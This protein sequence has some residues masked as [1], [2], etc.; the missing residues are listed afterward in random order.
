MHSWISSNEQSSVYENISE[1]SDT[2]ED[3]CNVPSPINYQ[4]NAIRSQY[5]HYLQSIDVEAIENRYHDSPRNS[6]NS[7]TNNNN[8]N[9]V[10]PENTCLIVGSSI[11]NNLD[12]NKLNKGNL[13]V[14]V[15]PFPG[16]TINNM[17]KPN[18]YGL[19]PSYSNYNFVSSPGP[20]A[21]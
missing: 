15:R 1:F 5:N 6:R 11:L 20:G 18:S 10:W 12:E 2:N 19:S 9:H 3:Y 4:N 17:E 16:S 14:K 21:F 7:S 13:V 8:N